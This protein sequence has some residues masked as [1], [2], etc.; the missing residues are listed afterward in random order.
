VDLLENLIQGLNQN[1]GSFPEFL[2]DRERD[3]RRFGGSGAKGGKE[4]LV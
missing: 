2:F 1:G 4:A 3:V